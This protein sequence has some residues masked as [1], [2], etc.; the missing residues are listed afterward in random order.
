MTARRHRATEVASFVAKEATRMVLAEG[1]DGQL[2]KQLV[3]AVLQR[4]PDITEGQTKEA[5]DLLLQALSE[6]EARRR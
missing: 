2:F 6:E 1:R 5:F 3:R 4:F